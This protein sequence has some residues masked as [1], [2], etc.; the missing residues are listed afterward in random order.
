LNK[1]KKLITVQELL[2]FGLQ[3][4]QDGKWFMLTG[5]HLVDQE[6]LNSTKRIHSVKKPSI[7]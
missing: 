2:P 7:I 1:K 4:V 6:F 3:L 5:H